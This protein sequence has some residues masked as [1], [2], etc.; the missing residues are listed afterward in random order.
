MKRFNW[1]IITA[2]VS[3]K[4]MMTI[5]PGGEHI[6]GTP[7]FYMSDSFFK[8][9]RNHDTITLNIRDLLEREDLGLSWCVVLPSKEHVEDFHARVLDVDPVKTLAGKYHHA[10]IDYINK[11]LS[12]CLV[13][14]LGSTDLSWLNAFIALDL[15]ETLPLESNWSM[16]TTSKQEPQIWV[17]RFRTLPLMGQVM[18]LSHLT[19]TVM[20]LNPGAFETFQKAAKDQGGLMVINL[21]GVEDRMASHLIRAAANRGGVMVETEDQADLDYFLSSVVPQLYFGS[22]YN[23]QFKQADFRTAIVSCIERNIERYRAI[24]THKIDLAIIDG[25]DGVW[26]KVGDMPVQPGYYKP[27]PKGGFPIE[28]MNNF[29]GEFDARGGGT[30]E[31]RGGEAVVMQPGYQTGS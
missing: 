22:T 10:M 7:Y 27:T 11:D 6:E 17:A 18:H 4:S 13:L 31:L 21:L 23:D 1:Y 16:K 28:K 2:T 24:K 8:G 19:E 9:M 3:E 26:S 20:S 15:P 12:G 5:V 30:V 25:I 14:D 29:R